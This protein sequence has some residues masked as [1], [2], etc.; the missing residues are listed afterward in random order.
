MKSVFTYSNPKSWPHHSEFENMKKAIHICATA[1]MK[2]GIAEVYGNEFPVIVTVRSLL[3]KIF[4]DWY[5]AE[6]QLQQYL[7]LSKLLNDF[8]FSDENL[9]NAFNINKE[10][11]LDTIRF[12]VQAGVSPQSLEEVEELSELER[13]FG[14]YG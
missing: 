2:K 13:V 12:L 8:K 3:A 14:K 9:K 6:R 7:C 5:S 1:N 11:I 10:Q 4:K